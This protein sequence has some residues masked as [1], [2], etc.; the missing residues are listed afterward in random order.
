MQIVA[1]TKLS[2]LTNELNRIEQMYTSQ[3]A[4]NVEFLN[5][6]ENV[7]VFRLCHYICC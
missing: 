4:K 7:S 2:G 1:A 5:A 6:I 3:K